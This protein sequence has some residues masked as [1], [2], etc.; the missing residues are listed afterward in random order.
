MK[1]IWDLHPFKDK[2]NSTSE[3]L[4]I[5]LPKKLSHYEVGK[6]LGGKPFTLNTY[7]DYSDNF[8]KGHWRGPYKNRSW[9]MGYKDLK[10]SLW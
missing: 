2:N 5:L 3:I 6:I 8:Y 1:N 9:K 7:I 10:Q 4:S